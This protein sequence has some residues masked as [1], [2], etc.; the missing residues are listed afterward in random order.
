M[1]LKDKLAKSYPGGEKSAAP[2][3]PSAASDGSKLSDA[4]EALLVLGYTRAEAAAALKKTD[5]AASLED[6]IR[7]ALTVLMKQ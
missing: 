5:P 1:D 4:Q 7:A 6:I 2:D 3:A